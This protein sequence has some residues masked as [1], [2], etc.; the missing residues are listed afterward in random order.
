MQKIKYMH[1]NIFNFYCHRKLTKFISSQIFLFLRY[2]HVIH[3]DIVKTTVF[4]CCSICNNYVTSRGMC[5][6]DKSHVHYTM[7]IATSDVLWEELL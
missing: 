1:I 7:A 3:K 5:L 6:C 4:L 2:V